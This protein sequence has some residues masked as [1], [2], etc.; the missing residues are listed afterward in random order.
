MILFGCA[1]FPEGGILRLCSRWRG[2]KLFGWPESGFAQRSLLVSNLPAREQHLK[3]PVL[4]SNGLHAWQFQ[5][6]SLKVKE[7]KHL[8]GAAWL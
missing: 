1:L 6:I 8:S 2:F 3:R 5:W 7:F 4:A